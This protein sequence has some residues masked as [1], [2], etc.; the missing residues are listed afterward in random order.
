MLFILIN[1][2]YIDTFYNHNKILKFTFIII[3]MLLYYIVKINGIY[4]II[5]ALSILNFTYFP[6][7]R[8]LHL[9]MIKKHNYQNNLFERFFAYWIFTYGVIRLYGDDTLISY[10]YYLE[11]IFFLNEYINNSSYTYK[12]FFVITSSL[13]LGYLCCLSI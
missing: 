7:L 5:C 12:S 6:K 3:N 9:S 8:Y 10:S 1:N 11:S 4:D 13:F 2:V